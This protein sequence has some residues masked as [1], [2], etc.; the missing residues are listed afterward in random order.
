[1]TRVLAGPYGFR[2]AALYEPQRFKTQLPA[3]RPLLIGGL[4]QS[5]DAA[6]ADAA[7]M[8]SDASALGDGALATW[9]CHAWREFA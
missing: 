3:P 8:E 7:A 1:M 9:A 5:A 4:R 2:A 6:R